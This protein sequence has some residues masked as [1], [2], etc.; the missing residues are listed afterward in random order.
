MQYTGLK[1]KGGVEI[2]VGDV[3][4]VFGVD[5]TVYYCDSNAGFRFQ[6]IKSP[7]TIE[8]LGNYS[9]PAFKVIG[10]IYENPELLES[11]LLESNQ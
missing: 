6:H 4:E 5:S 2:Y 1:D 10:N 9:A 8:P 7:F 11:E 3:I